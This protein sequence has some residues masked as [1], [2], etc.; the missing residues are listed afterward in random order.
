MTRRQF[1][2]L[3]RMSASAAMG[4]SGLYGQRRCLRGT[5][6]SKDQVA[7]VVLEL[8]LALFS[9][10]AAGVQ[11]GRSAAGFSSPISSVEIKQDS[12][13]EKCDAVYCENE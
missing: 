1:T 9:G 4:Q 10:G 7:G 12:R 11:P 6:Y 13:R 5:T 2:Y 3:V 8:G